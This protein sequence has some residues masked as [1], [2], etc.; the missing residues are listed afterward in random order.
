[1]PINRVLRTPMISLLIALSVA[2]LVLLAR[3][4][5]TGTAFDDD[6][7]RLIL[8]A[9]GCLAV[10]RLGL[11]TTPVVNDQACLFET[12]ADFSLKWVYLGQGGDLRLHPD[13]VI[14]AKKIR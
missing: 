13:R 5:L 3:V 1:M 14:A 6:R 2:L 4:S 11:T 10:A 12:S 7:Y 8:D 9:P